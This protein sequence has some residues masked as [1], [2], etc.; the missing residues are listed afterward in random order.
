MI[1]IT[2]FKKRQWFDEKTT[3]Y[4][5][6][7]EVMV[8]DAGLFHES[9]MFHG[10]SF[11]LGTSPEPSQLKEKRIQGVLWVCRQ[12]PPR[13]CNRKVMFLTLYNPTVYTSH[14]HAALGQGQQV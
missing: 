4:L 9:L 3:I 7:F 1:R 12:L 2:P 13:E 8:T 11:V 14:N 5:R 6:S 10:S